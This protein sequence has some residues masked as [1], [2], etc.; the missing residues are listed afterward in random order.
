MASGGYLAEIF[1]M[2]HC[3]DYAG[4]VML[5]WAFDE[6]YEHSPETGHAT[7]VTIGGSVASC[8]TWIALEA[9]WR[10]VLA[11][12]ALPEF[13]MTD[14]EANRALFTGWEKT[15]DRRRDL[16]ESLLDVMER[17]L[18]DFFGTTRELEPGEKNETVAYRL[19]VGDVIA[20]LA[21]YQSRRLNDEFGIVFARR[22]GFRT[23]LVRRAIEREGEEKFGPVISD[24]PIKIPALQAADIIAYETSRVQRAGRP[25]RYPFRRLC[26]AALR[27]GGFFSLVSR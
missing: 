8:D 24:R 11:R 19:C 17:H 27:S 4:V 22:K 14:F 15:P 5:W 2:A 18:R 10:A 13:H 9:D 23:D 21:R 26:E 6:S 1:A 20:E 7:R 16:L 25:E 3:D 12:F